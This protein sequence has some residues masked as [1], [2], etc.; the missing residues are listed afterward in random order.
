MVNEEKRKNLVDI[1]FCFCCQAKPSSLSHSLSPGWVRRHDTN[2]GMGTVL[3]MNILGKIRGIFAVVKKDM[4]G[5]DYIK[6]IWSNSL[7]Q[8]TI[9][10]YTFL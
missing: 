3:Y 8:R 6:Y 5:T 4:C 7:L 9:F 1:G 10:I 2:T